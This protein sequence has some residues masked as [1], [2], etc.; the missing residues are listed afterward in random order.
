MSEKLLFIVAAF[1]MLFSAVALVSLCRP[2]RQ[3]STFGIITRKTLKPP[4]VY[5]QYPVGADRSLRTATEIPIAEAHV[6]EIAADGLEGPLF[7]SLNTIASKEFEVG[8]KV[9]V[10]Y[11]RRGIP[12]IWQRIF[13]EKMV[14]YEQ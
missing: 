2:A 12:F 10:F 9:R 4:G 3:E 1:F 13:V 5:A 8:Q 6:F 11:R 14:A 7:F